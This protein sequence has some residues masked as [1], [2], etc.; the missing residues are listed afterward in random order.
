MNSILDTST[1][2]SAIGLIIGVI[3]SLCLILVPRRYVVV[4]VFFLVCYMTMGERILV[5]GLNF[6]MLRLLLLAGW[7][8][9]L[10]RKEFAL[11]SFNA[12]DTIVIAWT[13]VRTVNYTL[14]WGTTA[15]LVNRLGYAYDIMGA[16]FLFRIL[17]RHEEEVLRAIRYLAAFIIPLAICMV[18]EKLTARNVFSIFG[19][20]PFMPEVRD[21]V[22]RCQGPFSHPILAG[23]FG[24]TNLPLLLALWWRQQAKSVLPLI[25]AIAA[26]VITAMAGSSGPALACI[27][28]LMGICFWAI[29]RHMRIVLWSAF[30]LAVALQLAMRS[31]VWFLLGRLG[32]FSGSTGW[33]RGFL[34]DMAFR[35]IGDWWLIGTTAAATWHPFL[36]DVTNQYIEEGFCGGLIAMALFIAILAAGFRTV[37][38]QVRWGNSVVGAKHLL[39]AFGAALFAHAVSFVSVTYFDQNFVMLYFLLAAIS[40]C[41]TMKAVQAS[42]Q[43]QKEPHESPFA[44][45]FGQPMIHSAAKH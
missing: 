2:V 7:V 23:T 33:F 41:G 13:I 43:K 18:I 19:G 10:I 14:V 6:T 32:V 31:P 4:P 24:A 40:V 15:A 3:A 29:R 28:G 1:S 30:L 8:R 45:S 44:L 22:V 34:I 21:G 35:H 42:A 26:L 25:S 11:P 38:R 37:G 16:Y 17:L 39:W 36:I 27:A 5:L 12:I 20:V 9:V